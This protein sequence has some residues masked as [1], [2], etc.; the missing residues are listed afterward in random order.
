M[1]ESLNRHKISAAFFSR[2]LLKQ[3]WFFVLLS[4]LYLLQNLLVRELLAAVRLHPHIETQLF[5]NA[6]LRAGGPDGAGNGASVRAAGA[7]FTAGCSA[8]GSTAT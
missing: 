7:A 6:A 1:G 8:A 5:D 4:H 3:Q 2:K